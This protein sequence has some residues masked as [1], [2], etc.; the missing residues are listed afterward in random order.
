MFP[1]ETRI[2]VVDDMAAMRLRVTNQLK[3]M[4]FN[5]IEQAGNGKE[6][7]AQLEKGKSEGKNFSLIISDWNMPEMT[8]IDFLVAVRAH[9]T[10]KSI[11]F[12]MVT[13]EGEKQQVVRALKSGV[14]DYLIKPVDKIL[15][16]KKLISI[17]SK[18]SAA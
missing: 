12:L 18:L 15:L 11:P 6:A 3:S 17:W 1:L 9:E 14:S 13:A 2:L 4:G 7:L 10:F 5:D 8:G 16:E